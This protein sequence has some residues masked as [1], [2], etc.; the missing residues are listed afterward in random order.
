MKNILAF[1]ILGIAGLFTQISAQHYGGS[2]T[3]IGNGYGTTQIYTTPRGT[4]SVGTTRT[5]TTGGGYISTTDVTKSGIPK[6]SSTT[7]RDIWGNTITT[8]IYHN[9]GR[10]TTTYKSR[11]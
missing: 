2:T 10:T 3:R 4:T 9:T 11:Y 1:T 7:T 5:Y 8:K 6:T